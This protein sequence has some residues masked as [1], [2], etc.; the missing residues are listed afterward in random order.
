MKTYVNTISRLNLGKPTVFFPMGKGFLK[1]RSI[2]W[3][4]LW[5]S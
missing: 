3:K 1:T 2:L 4:Q 5:S